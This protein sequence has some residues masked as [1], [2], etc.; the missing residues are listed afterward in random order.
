MSA[1]TG[2]EGRD[3]ATGELLR[4]RVEQGVI[5][6][7]H[8]AADHPAEVPFVSPGLVDLQVNGFVGHDVNAEEPTPEAIVAI[9]AALAER[10]VTT[11]VPTVVTAPEDAIHAAIAA[12]RRAREQ[13]PHAHAAI[14]FIHVEGP[15]LSDHPGP[16]GVHAPDAIRPIDAAE[17]ERWRQTGPVGYVTVSPHWSNSAAEIARIR[18][19]G[20]VVAIGHTHANSEMI[21]AAVDAGAELSTHLGNGIFPELPRHPNPIW[22]QLADDRLTCGFIADGHH[23]PADTLKAMIRAKGTHRSFLVSDSVELA[24][25]T[26]GRYETAVGGLVELDGSGRLSYVGTDLL[27]GAAVSLGEGLRF[28]VSHVGLSLAEALG[29]VTS[30]PGRIVQSCGSRPRGLLRVGQPADLVLLTADGSVQATMR[31]GGLL[32]AQG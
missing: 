6:E 3:P 22:T 24:G 9:T 1:P 30:V 14:P 4:I 10:G 13:D 17:V 23:L 20:T 19:G 21:T 2:I 26:P 31:S 8:R 29:L 28:L 32:G 7:I 25:S 5:A 27:A 16:R 15:F 18:Q 12:V 11:W